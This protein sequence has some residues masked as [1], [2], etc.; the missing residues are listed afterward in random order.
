MSTRE[1]KPDLESRMIRIAISVTTFL[2]LL[3]AP[4]AAQQGQADALLDGARVTAAFDHQLDALNKK[5]AEILVR[6][7][8]TTD[9]LLSS[10]LYGTVDR[11]T[12]FPR[13]VNLPPEWLMRSR[14][15]PEVGGIL[16]VAFAAAL[17]DQTDATLD[18]PL[19]TAA[20]DYR[21]DA[22]NEKLAE[23][24]V[25]PLPTT[26]DLLS[27]TVYGTMGDLRAPS[28]TWFRIPLR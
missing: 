15:T 25:P 6:P 26:A 4:A 13:G 9:E 11:R 21:P 1:L 23:I 2:A 18:G 16:L 20:F 14:T 24:L 28:M 10:T 5:L 8:P 12:N 17:Q 19:G 7:L 22:L 27:S 3:V